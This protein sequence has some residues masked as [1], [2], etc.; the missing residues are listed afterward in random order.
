MYADADEI[1]ADAVKQGEAAWSNDIRWS[2]YHDQH[3]CPA[4]VSKAVSA[5]R[6]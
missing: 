3:V 4:C 5:L 1:W 6:P 2:V